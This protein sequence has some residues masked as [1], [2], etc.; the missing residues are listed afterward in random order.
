LFLAIYILNGNLQKYR[1][2]DS[3]TKAIKLNSQNLDTGCSELD[4]M[5]KWIEINWL[6]NP[7]FRPNRIGVHREIKNEIENICPDKIRRNCCE[8]YHRKMKCSL[9]TQIPRIH[10]NKLVRNW[11]WNAYF[12][13]KNEQEKG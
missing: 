11:I 2:V 8:N 9:R 6:L 12:L 4:K 3:L 5:K 13:T 1:L 10:Q 7:I